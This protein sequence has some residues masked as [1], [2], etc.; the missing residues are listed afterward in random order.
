[1]AAE[2]FGLSENPFKITP[3]L[4]F[5]H[6]GSRF[7]ATLREV[8][9]TVLAGHGIAVVVARPGMGKTMLLNLLAEELR[10]DRPG[11]AVALRNCGPDSRVEDFLTDLGAAPAV[12]LLDEAQNLAADE[13]RRLDQLTDPPESTGETSG[14]APLRIALAGTP[15]LDALVAADRTSAL[16]RRIA[17]YRRLDPLTEP[18]VEAF[19]GDRLKAIGRRRVDL[20][21]DA[22]V[23]AIVRY[24]SGVPRLINNLCA[25]ALFLAE[26]EGMRRVS[27]EF[28]TEAAKSLELLPANLAVFEGAIADEMIVDGTVEASSPSPPAAPSAERRRSRLRLGLAAAVGATAAL[29]LFAIQD[30]FVSD[31]VAVDEPTQTETQWLPTPSPALAG[32]WL[33]E[34]GDL[35]SRLNALLARARE[36]VAALALT[37][38]AGDNAFETYQEILTL[39]PGNGDA[40]RGIYDLGGSYANL[41]ETAARRGRRTAAR[42]YYERG[43]AVAPQHPALLALSERSWVEP[44]RRR[45]QEAQVDTTAPLSVTEP[46]TNRGSRR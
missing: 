22:A 45:T 12:L 35:D 5:V 38:P 40:L 36:Q 13:F 25:T 33:E 6:G 11:W 16:Q 42:I 39:M 26:F 14:G 9:D 41:A 3:D 23:A 30:D 7:Q 37:T 15:S 34:I 31:S 21:S 17:L 32:L 20:F 1:M 27:A 46:W 29:V 4:R 2:L 28:V 43:L 18:E 8:R 10:R 44:R 19:I 24:S